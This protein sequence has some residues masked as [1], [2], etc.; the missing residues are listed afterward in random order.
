MKWDGVGWD[1]GAV[2]QGKV[3]WGGVRLDWIGYNVE[4]NQIR[5]GG[6]WARQ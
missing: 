6:R 4:Y 5:D 3:E 1:L 2:D